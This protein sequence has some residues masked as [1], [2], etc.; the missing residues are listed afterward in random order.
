MLKII[1]RFRNEKMKLH[2]AFLFA[3]PLVL[4]S[5]RCGDKMKLMPQLNY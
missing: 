1:Q 4:N 2:F 3:S 5:V